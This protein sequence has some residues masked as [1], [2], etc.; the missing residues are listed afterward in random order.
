[1][2]RGA[3]DQGGHQRARDAPTEGARR[4]GQSF[5][6][7]PQAELKAAALSGCVCSRAGSFSCIAAPAGLG[8]LALVQPSP[9]GEGLRDLARGWGTAAL[10]AASI[11]FLLSEPG[12]RKKPRLSHTQ[13]QHY[14]A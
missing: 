12:A 5:R 11:P 2:L 10:G 8:S 14:G 1:M 13:N 6:D 9:V 4:S 7:G 3:P